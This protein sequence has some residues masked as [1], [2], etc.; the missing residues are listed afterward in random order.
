MWQLPL[1]GHMVNVAWL[2]LALLGWTPCLLLASCPLRFQVKPAGWAGALV[3]PQ[4]QLW[5]CPALPG[6]LPGLGS[7][8]SQHG[9]A[10]TRKVF[11]RAAH[12]HGEL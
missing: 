4:K 7:L 2:A 11:R 6:T 10:N 1:R 5:Q 3:G 12:M 8:P 9:S